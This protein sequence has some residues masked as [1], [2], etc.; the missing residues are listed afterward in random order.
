LLDKH[1]QFG[2]AKAY[3]IVGVGTEIFPLITDSLL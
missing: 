1:E 2:N 3:T